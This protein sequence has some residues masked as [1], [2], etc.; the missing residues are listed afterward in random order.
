MHVTYKCV[1]ML[2][3]LCCFLQGLGSEGEVATLAQVVVVHALGD[4]GDGIIA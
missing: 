1:C 2:A 3:Y 4:L